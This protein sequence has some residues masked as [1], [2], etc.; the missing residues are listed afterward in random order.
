MKKL[1]IMAAMLAATMCATAQ[2]ITR[3][4][5][6]FTTSGRATMDVRANADS[7]A[8]RW[9]DSNGVERAIWIART[10][11][12]FVIKRSQRT[13]NEYRQYCPR[14]MSESI[15]KEM[16]REYKPSAKK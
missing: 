15:C 16:G 2:S 13:G 12:C 7:T 11:S 9:R 8:L 4:G 3:E 1:V 10:G 5:N 14:V 6:V